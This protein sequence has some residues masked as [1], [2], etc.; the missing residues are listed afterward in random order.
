M[1]LYFDCTTSNQLCQ[2]NSQH[3]EPIQVYRAKLRS[4]RIVL[5]KVCQSQATINQVYGWNILETFTPPTAGTYCPACGKVLGE[6]EVLCASGICSHCC[7][8]DCAVRRICIDCHQHI[9]N[10]TTLCSNKRCANCCL[11]SCTLCARCHLHTA[12][13]CQNNHC[14]A[15]CPVGCIRC[16]RCNVHNPERRCQHCNSCRSCC[17]CRVCNNCSRLATCAACIS[18]RTHCVCE[19]RRNM[20]QSNYG[21]AF[22]AKNRTDRKLFDC[23]RLVGVEWEYNSAANG[24]PLTNWKTKWHSQLIHDGSCGLEAVTPPAAGDHMVNCLR[25]LGKAFVEGRAE[26]DERCGIHVHIDSSDLSWYDMR[27]LL[28]TY[29]QVEPILYMLAGQNRINNRYCIPCGDTYI[30]AMNRLPTQVQID[31]VEER[32]KQVEASLKLRKLPPLDE[33]TKRSWREKVGLEA[34]KDGILEVAFNQRRP[35]EARNHQR[36]KPSKKD[37]SRY[38]GL[39][40][41][42]WLA[43]RRTRAK[44]TTLEFRLHRNVRG[45][46]AERVVNW[47]KLCARLVDWSVKASDQE[48]KNLPK[49]ALKALC[50]V[51]A[52]ECAPYIKER[53]QLWR[54]ATSFQMGTRRKIY[55][56][57]GK[58][59][60]RN[61]D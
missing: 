42:P 18:C 22:E 41:C 46:D 17:Q 53:V 56:D 40:L 38:K 59:C 15:C 44:D 31:V 5:I 57:K 6:G 21:A 39:N 61:K 52:P 9:N 19:Q 4:G 35:E 30:K 10:N 16:A 33:S 37:G 13:R 20:S 8:Y 25:E 50:N 12:D 36:N 51:I 1:R 27:R 28:H 47:A 23:S 55:L 43:G 2:E 26:I 34:V 7:G 3:N 29:A 24:T 58:Y 60:M 14:S 49:S 48:A 32:I 45:D 54:K 11:N